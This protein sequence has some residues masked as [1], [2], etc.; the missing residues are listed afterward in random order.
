MEIN[1]FHVNISQSSNQF[2]FLP[3]VYKFSIARQI[4]VLPIVHTK[5]LCN[6][7]NLI[8]VSSTVNCKTNCNKEL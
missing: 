3:P 4:L 1:V 8:T 7:D 6:A 2:P 5:A